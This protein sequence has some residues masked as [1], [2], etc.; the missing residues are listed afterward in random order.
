MWLVSRFL[1]KI[2]IFDHHRHVQSENLNFSKNVGPMQDFAQNCHFWPPLICWGWKFKFFQKFWPD[3]GF[4]SKIVIFDHRGHVQAKNFICS[5]KCCP[6]IRTCR[7]W[8]FQSFQ[9]YWPNQRFC[10]KLSFFATAFMLKMKIFNFSQNFGPIQHF[11]QKLS[12]LTTADMSRL[13]MSIFPKLLARSRIL[14]KIVIFW[15][16][17]GTTADMSMQ[18]E[19]FN[20]SKNSWPDEEFCSKVSF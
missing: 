18:S 3:Q 4:C 17:P 16:P 13:K 14:L 1:L 6:V 19:N 10:S 9:K 8:K 11:A 20:F 7:G 2:V 5:N 12:F 15:P